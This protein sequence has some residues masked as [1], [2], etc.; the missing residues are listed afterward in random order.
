MDCYALV[1]AWQLAQAGDSGVWAHC[2]DLHEL[3]P[4]IHG[5]AHLSPVDTDNRDIL[6]IA[7]KH[8]FTS[9]RQ[10]QGDD[11]IL[12][13]L[14]WLVETHGPITAATLP[15]PDIITRLAHDDDYPFSRHIKQD[16]LWHL[17]R[18][19]FHRGILNITLAARL[20]G[21]EKN[22]THAANR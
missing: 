14:E 2:Q 12:D 11:Y 18:A 3:Q 6:A 16:G 17:S 15:G 5:L 8:W 22:I 20:E 7:I 13:W 1:V 9:E 21:L 10:H 4:V 19:D